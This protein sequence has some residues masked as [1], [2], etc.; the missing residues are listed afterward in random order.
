MKAYQLVDAV[1]SM[2]NCHSKELA[3]T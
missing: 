1:V 2:S 3:K